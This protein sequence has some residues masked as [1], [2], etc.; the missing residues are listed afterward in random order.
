MVQGMISRASNHLA[1]PTIVILR[2]EFEICVAERIYYQVSD[3]PA[4]D[5]ENI[6]AKPMIDDGQ[7]AQIPGIEDELL[8]KRERNC[9]QPAV[10]IAF[11]VL[12]MNPMEPTHVKHPMRRIV[13][14]LSP[15]CRQDQGKNE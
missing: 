15:D 4:A 7:H 13:P 11:V 9:C 8:G 5:T 12:A 14:N 6:Q 10:Q 1:K 2:F 3:V